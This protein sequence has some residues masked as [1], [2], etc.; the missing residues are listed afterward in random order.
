MTALTS[1]AA[2][3]VQRVS[4]FINPDF[5][6]TLNEKA[7]KLDNPVLS[8]EG[9]TYVY[10]K[11][12]GS[13]V[14]TDVAW[15]STTKTVEISS[16]TS[17]S[18]ESS[19][20]TSTEQKPPNYEKELGVPYAKGDFSEVYFINNKEYVIA[21]SIQGKLQGTIYSLPYF[22]QEKKLSLVTYNSETKEQTVLIGDIPFLATKLNILV[23]YNYYENTIKPLIAL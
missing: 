16:T 8:Y 15:N 21:D 5:K 22:Y 7:V 17:G 13:L 10:L 12:V 1:Y 18:T 9:K 23:E 4:A 2:P 6:M 19:N 3:T 20:S 14:D 11:D